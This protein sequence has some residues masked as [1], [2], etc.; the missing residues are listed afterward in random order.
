M[1]FGLAQIEHVKGL[2]PVK[3]DSKPFC[4]T[5]F[6]FSHQGNVIKCKNLQRCGGAGDASG[7]QDRWRL[8]NI[9]QLLDQQ[10][11]AVFE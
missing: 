1:A 4:Y 10:D 11:A 3:I 9:C 7:I 8:W 6:N 2:L 5:I